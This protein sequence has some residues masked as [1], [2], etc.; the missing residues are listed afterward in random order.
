MITIPANVAPGQQ[1]IC[2]LPTPPEGT[3]PEPEPAPDAW[4]YVDPSGNQHGPH[5]A[6]E[7]SGWAPYFPPTTNVLPPGGTAWAPITSFPQVGL[8]PLFLRFS[9][10]KCRNCPFFPCILIRNE[11]KNRS[12]LRGGGTAD[13]T[14]LAASGV[15]W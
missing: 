9:I 4:Y 2:T 1:F 6:A 8:S 11:G 5:T 12:D 3:P 10:G 7:M 13:D 15:R 14:A